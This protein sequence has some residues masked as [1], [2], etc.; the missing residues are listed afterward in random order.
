MRQETKQ[1]DRR[2]QEIANG[3]KIRIVLATR[4]CELLNTVRPLTGNYWSVGAIQLLEFEQHS[5]IVLTGFL[6]RPAISTVKHHIMYCV[7]IV[8]TLLASGML[9]VNAGNNAFMSLHLIQQGRCP[10]S[11]SWKRKL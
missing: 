7:A 3:A 5:S 8:L 4:S 10:F 1:R 2:L 6:Q 9:A 11:M